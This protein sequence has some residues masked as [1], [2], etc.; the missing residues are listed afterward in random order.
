MFH[1][2]NII[3][4]FSPHCTLLTTSHPVK[5]TLGLACHITIYGTNLGSLREHLQ[6]H[7]RQCYDM[8]KGDEIHIWI[9]DTGEWEN[10]IVNIMT[11]CGFKQQFS[12]PMKKFYCVE[13]S[14][15]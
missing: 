11:D 2:T 8:A 7:I 12:L 6:Y 4:S 9:H 10:A 5:A 15:V 14:I 1:S 3:G 13:K